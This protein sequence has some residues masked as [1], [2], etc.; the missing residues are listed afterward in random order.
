MLSSLIKDNKEI[1]IFALI[2]FLSIFMTVYII[3]KSNKSHNKN[4][5]DNNNS[6]YKMTVF[7]KGNPVDETNIKITE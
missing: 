4:K 5:K 3:I 6:D 1:I 7:Y 2:I